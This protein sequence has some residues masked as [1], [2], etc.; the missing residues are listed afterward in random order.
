MAYH[1]GQKK[2]KT[3]KT[4]QK[5]GQKKSNVQTTVKNVGGKFQAQTPTQT[6]DDTRSDTENIVQQTQAA[7]EETQEQTNAEQMVQQMMTAGASAES[8]YQQ[9]Q[10]AQQ[11]TQE[12]APTELSGTLV[13][14]TPASNTWVVQDINEDINLIE[15]GMNITLLQ[16]GQTQDFEVQSISGTTIILNESV[17]N[18]NIGSTVEFFI[19]TP[20]ENISSQQ[21]QEPEL[22]STEP[23]PISPPTGYTPYNPMIGTQSPLGQWTWSGTGWNHNDGTRGSFNVVEGGEPKP[24]SPPLDI[25]PMDQKI[26]TL[27]PL[28]QWVWQGLNGG[29]VEY[30]KPPPP[31]PAPPPPPDDPRYEVRTTL[32]PGI[33]I[34]SFYGLEAYRDILEDFVF[35]NRIDF[36][37]WQDY[38]PSSPSD[39]QSEVPR[40]NRTREYL[41]NTILKDVPILKISKLKADG[42]TGRY[43]QPGVPMGPQPV[44]DLPTN[45]SQRLDEIQSVSTDGSVNFY[46]IEVGISTSTQAAGGTS[47]VLQNRYD[48]TYLGLDDGLDD[49][50]YETEPYEIVPRSL[51]AAYQYRFTNEWAPEFEDVDIPINQFCASCKFYEPDGGYC[52]KWNAEV[53][54]AYWCAAW[55]QLEYVEAPPNQ[56]TQFMRARGA[57]NSGPNDY[58][59]NY[60]L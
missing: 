50:Y 58:I 34:R 46:V 17:P 35:M 47:G 11:E 55:Q 22:Y 32:Y 29:W 6:V 7:Q 18:Q 28:E 44:V 24:T 51:P 4:K 12:Q 59:Y 53:R 5:K 60:Y 56:F 49:R 13:M 45:P 20:P 42:T 43:F 31:L 16:F 1:G 26:G 33:N 57:N 14:P 36:T 37:D 19:T 10:A 23:M 39:Y 40:S 9:T 41:M 15:A 52:N 3:K 8:M 2:T 25:S 27:S 48:V 30:I 54:L 38:W 21:T